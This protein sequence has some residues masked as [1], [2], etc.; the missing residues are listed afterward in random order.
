MNAIVVVFGGR[1]IRI[2]TQ[3]KESVCSVD[4]FVKVF[5]YSGPFSSMIALV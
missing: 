2:M 1:I 4:L 3:M 5:L